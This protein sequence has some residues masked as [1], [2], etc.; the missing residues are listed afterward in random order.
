MKMLP[1]LFGIAAAVA[2][3]ATPVTAQSSY[4]ISA[5]GEVDA[6]NGVAAI[7]R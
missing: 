4:E 3:L 2:D 7:R 6:V 5:D 1:R